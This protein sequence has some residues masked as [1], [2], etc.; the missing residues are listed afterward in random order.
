[1]FHFRRLLLTGLVC[2]LGSAF[3][4][5]QQRSKVELEPSETL[6]TV[7]T[8]LNQ[9]GYDDDLAN[10]DP[11]REEVRTA[12]QRAIGQS[13]E[14]NTASREM[15]AFY[16]DHV[17]ND[18][19]RDLSQYI[20]LALNLGPAPDF[21]PRVK[22]ADL[23]P[24]ASYVLG[25][26]PLVATFYKTVHLNGIWNQVQP[27]YEQIMEQVHDSLANM[28][29]ATDIYLKIPISG[30]SA[31]HMVIYLEPMA[32]PGQVNARNY[33]D[34]Y[35]LVVSPSGGT[36]PLQQIRHTYL[37]FTLD[38][39]A[40]KRP[41]AMKKLDPILSQI[42]NASLDDE[43]K[44]DAALLVTESLIRAIEAR[45]I[46]GKNSEPAREEEVG[47]DMAEGFVLTRYFY[48]ALVKFEPEPTSLK[49]AFPD[50]LYYMDI[51]KQRKIAAETK[52]TVK[53]PA[54]IVKNKT[55]GRPQAASQIDV[56]EQKMSAGDLAGAEK[57]ALEVASANGS[58]SSRAYMLLGQIATLNRD[59]DNAIRYFETTLRTAKDPRLIAWSHIYLG[60]IY[61]VD[62]E[63]DMAVKH[64]QA[65][66]RSGDDSPQI[67]AAA[68][69]GLKSAYERRG[70][71]DKEK[72]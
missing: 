54:E 22:E 28:I 61:D 71:S 34:D 41:V 35:F 8:A 6:F 68:E 48:D 37:H 31:R 59:K 39:L 15:C 4:L 44:R 3:A 23:P 62:Q 1:V 65:A 25:F 69:R 63:R 11:V 47:K 55:T 2:L 57:I 45:M 33:G 67:K 42:Q 14:A 51:S 30:S 49:D 46:P 27:R 5:G 60:R 64:Y 16:R 26:V 18:P 13:P 38:S 29:L 19:N 32:G 24:D 70:S 7:V 66:L 20:S 50:W 43:Y 17:A 40:L 12:V 56:A 9:C 72:Q 58:D 21:K 10:S 53:A 52:F 36:L